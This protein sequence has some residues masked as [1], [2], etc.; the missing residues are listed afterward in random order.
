MLN[1]FCCAVVVC[2]GAPGLDWIK[3]GTATGD[4]LGLVRTERFAN[5]GRRAG[6]F[7]EHGLCAG[8]SPIDVGSSALLAIAIVDFACRPAG[9]FG[10]NH[11]RSANNAL[12]VNCHSSSLPWRLRNSSAI[13]PR[14]ADSSPGQNMAFV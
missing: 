4:G 7:T 1:D 2:N 8:S 3:C 12:K 10:C 5:C 13:P 11:A 9:H 14:L 6:G